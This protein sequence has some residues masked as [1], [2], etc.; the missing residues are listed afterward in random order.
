MN[1]EEAKLVKS[2]EGEDSFVLEARAYVEKKKKQ[3][4]ST[5]LGWQRASNQ[6]IFQ[7]GMEAKMNGKKTYMVMY[8]DYQ[9]SKKYNDDRSEIPKLV[10]KRSKGK[11]TCKYVP[12]GCFRFEYI[13]CRF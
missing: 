12:G 3:Q 4:E 10:E 6:A 13:E 9:L 7:K 1:E 8:E 2:E 11:I 5:E